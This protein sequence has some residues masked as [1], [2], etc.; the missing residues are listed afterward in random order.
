VTNAA[1]VELLPRAHRELYPYDKLDEFFANAPVVGFPEAGDT[2]VVQHQEWLTEWQN[3][4]G[5]N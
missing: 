3:I 4:Q 1:A 2:D 5:G